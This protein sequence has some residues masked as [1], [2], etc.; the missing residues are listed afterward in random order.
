MRREP[1]PVA[2]EELDE[3][4]GTFSWQVLV[5]A[6]FGHAEQHLARLATTANL[7]AGRA[8]EQEKDAAVR[9]K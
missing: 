9:A 7:G 4:H 6:F 5:P 1:Q 3:L 8:S 2:Q